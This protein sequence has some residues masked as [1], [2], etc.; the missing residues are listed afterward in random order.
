MADERTASV[1]TWMNSALRSRMKA[2]TIIRQVQIR[3]WYLM[4]PQVGSSMIPACRDA[5]VGAL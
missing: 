4:D 2:S 5:E 1:I 3:Q